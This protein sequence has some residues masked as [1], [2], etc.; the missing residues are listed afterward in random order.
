M[1]E[2]KKYGFRNL[3]V[4]FFFFFFVLSSG[5]VAGS[6]RVRGQMINSGR[7]VTEI[8]KH[9]EGRSRDGFVFSTI[10]SLSYFCSTTSPFMCFINDYTDNLE[11]FGSLVKRHSTY[12]LIVT[13]G[14]HDVT[15]ECRS[16][17]SAGVR[18]SHTSRESSI[19]IVTKQKAPSL[20]GR[21][22]SF[23]GQ[24]SGSHC[25]RGRQIG[26]VKPHCE[27]D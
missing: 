14:H 17:G 26:P 18:R 8:T 5:Q 19:A 15:R 16:L 3:F 13:H 24:W 22:G 2:R 4:F 21:K 10:E 25:P 23:E 27:S 7:L 11:S 12:N 1:T 6:D 9:D 20:S